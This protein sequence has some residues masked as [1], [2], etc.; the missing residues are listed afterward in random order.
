MILLHF[1]KWQQRL[2][3][4]GRLQLAGS[5]PP[6]L[7]S[8]LPPPL[9]SFPAFL[10]FHPAPILPSDPSISSTGTGTSNVVQLL[11]ERFAVTR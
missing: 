10:F 7:A 4:R 9:P 5:D 1:L 6:S 2:R 8:S 11:I 3:M